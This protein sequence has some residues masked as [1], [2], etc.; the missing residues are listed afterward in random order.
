MRRASR[1]VL[2]LAAALL[3][4]SFAF[5]QGTLTGTVR[6]ESGGVLPGVTV[7]ASS[8]VLIEKVRAA[9]T[10]TAGQYRIT[11]LNPGTYSLVFKLTGFNVVR[12]EG[13]ELSGTA[14]LTIP[15]EMHLGAVAETVTVTGETPVVDVQTTQRETVLSADVVAA[16]PGNRS[17]GTLLNAVPGL[18]VNDGALAAS[19][20]MTLF[21]A[22][23][24]PINEG[25][26]AINGM[27]VA[28]PFNGGG[29]STYI[30]DSVNVDEIAV[31]VGGGLGESDIGGPV[32]NLIPRSGGN[33]FRGQGFINNSGDW[34][35]GNN[36][37][38]ELRAV[39]I[40]ETPGIINSYDASGSY[41]GPIARDRLWFFGSY[42]SLKTASAVQGVVA[43]AN[44]FDASRWDWVADPSVT[45]RQVQRRESYV[46]RFTAQLSP[47]N[48][49]SF[50]HEYQRRCEGSPLKVES[51]GC[52]TRDAGWIAA[53]TAT[54]S[55]E[56][57]PNY[58][59]NTPYRVTQGMWSAPM[60][61]RLLLEAGYTWF[62]FSGGTTGSVPPDGIFDLI[63]VTEQSSG[64]NPATGLQ[65]APRANFVY[66]G[67][68]T[69]NPNYANPNNWRASV[70]Y[71]TGSHDLKIGYQ[72]A[73]IRVD[74]WFLVPASQ[75]SY[76]FNQGTPNQFTYRLP[77]WDQA[78]RTST[79]AL[80][81]QDRWTRGRLTLQGALRYDRASSFSPAEHNGTD[82]TSRFNPAPITFARTVGVDAFNDI[83]PRFGV[84]YDVFGT[85]TTAVKFNLGHYLDAATNDSE[86]TSN[87][88]AVRI[89]RTASR[90]WQDTNNNKVIDCDIM[91]PAANLECAAATGDALNF[92]GVSGNVT[93]VN[94]AT[95]RG[96]GV[97]QHDWQWGITVQQQVIPRVSAEIS[98]NRRWFKGA[99]V[100]DDTLRGPADYEPFTILAPQDPRL[101]GG[102]GYPITLSMV[103]PAAAARGTQNYVTFETDFGPER[104]QYW[105]GVD[106]TLNARLR[107]G[108]TLQFGTQ[109]GRSIEDACEIAR[110]SDGTIVAATPNTAAT[111]SNLGTIKDLRSCRD[112][113]PFQT[114]V[115][116]LASY[117]VPKVDVL[118]SATVRSQPPLERTA[119]WQVPNTVIQNLT[120]RLPPGGLPTGQHQ[121]RDPGQRPSAVRRQSADAGRHA[122]RQNHQDR[123]QARGH[124]RR[125]RQPAQQQLH[126]DV[127]EHVSVQRRQHRRRGHL[128]QPDG[129]LHAALRPLESDRRLLTGR[130][131]DL[132]AL[133][134]PVIT[135]EWRTHLGCNDDPA[136][137]R[138][139]ANAP[140]RHLRPE[141]ER[142]FCAVRDIPSWPGGIPRDGRSHR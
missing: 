110:V 47:R 29:V 55:P 67:V 122:V 83:T 92:G 138:F 76:R 72:G 50:N 71:V 128:E 131:C 12:R 16:M 123:P 94:Q 88:P 117:T 130:A 41:G 63:S 136:A 57:N 40:R 95:L 9:L 98:Y 10:D 17:V 137:K 113:D 103:T 69:A 114:T 139:D 54:T 6:D 18:N 119:T 135:G 116:G 100:T 53:G 74:W 34:S 127:R 27:T 111:L 39:G 120:G 82:L 64:I 81:I 30:L 101:P 23:G 11:G 20:T 33:T 96:W 68:P 85:G 106:F 37:N 13:I 25:R 93:Q 38:D 115:R 48:R 79:S 36:L 124:R 108:L 14:T 99:K 2:I 24:G 80:Y 105:H 58:F 107:Q 112:A 19:P 89:V 129:D 66:R 77:E 104:T 75:L 121:H 102:G 42:R 49:L 91:N 73:Y 65:Y 3:L 109:T 59:G 43:N 132:P 56:A 62:S 31:S 46:G 126:D 118:V 45:A 125:P 86:Y 140:L 8:P 87:S 70:S 35:R 32:M 4:P 84:A 78:D 22:R 52:N 51:D 133:F 1:P 134:G 97:R 142:I 7:E 28:A 90:N 5:A 15:I 141:S 61:S 44:A 60:T 21:A 26:M